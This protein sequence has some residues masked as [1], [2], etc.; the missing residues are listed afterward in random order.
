MARV[1]TKID[2][3]YLKG[4]LT[5]DK[6]LT[7]EYTSDSYIYKVSYNGVK[8]LL[9]GFRIDSVFR[10]DA[11]IKNIYQEYFSLKAACKSNSHIVKPLFLDYNVNV[12]LRNGLQ[13]YIE[14][15][16]ENPGMSL[17]EYY[18]QES[19]SL[20]TTYNLMKQSINT[21]LLLQ[22]I[23]IPYFNINPLNM[24]LLDFNENMVHDE[25]ILKIIDMGKLHNRVEERI[26]NNVI[27]FNNVLITEEYSPPEVLRLYKKVASATELNMEAVMVH[28]WAM[29]FNSLILK[30]NYSEP[31]SEDIKCKL[32]AEKDYR[33]YIP[34]ADNNSNLIVS[35][36]TIE[37]KCFIKRIISNALEYTP[38]KRPKIRDIVN[39][40]VEFEK[41]KEINLIGLSSLVDRGAI[42]EEKKSDIK[43]CGNCDER[44]LKK[45]ELICGH[46]ICKDCLIEYALKKFM[47]ITLYKYKFKCSICNQYNTLK[48]IELDCGCIESDFKTNVKKCE[49]EHLLTSIDLGLINDYTSFEHTTIMAKDHRISGKLL[50]I[51]N[52]ALY[53]RKVEEMAWAIRYVITKFSLK[54]KIENKEIG[55]IGKALEVSKEIIILDL[56]SNEIKKEGAKIIS[57]ALEINTTLK[58]LH[59][60]QNEI[61]NEGAKAIGEMLRVNKTL[62]ELDLTN[63]NIG[64]EG[65][66]AIVKGLKV[67]KMLTKLNLEKNFIGNLIADILKTNKILTELKLQVNG[68]GHTKS[69]G[70]G[71]MVN[72]II[73]ILDLENNNIGQES[74]ESISKA[75]KT[76]SSLKS[77]NL[78]F[79]IIKNEGA[80]HIGEALRTNKN[81]KELYLWSNKIEDAI[82]IGNGLKF[83]ENLT[84]LE[85]GGNM[86]NK[87]SIKVISEALV[88]KSKLRRLGL[89]YNHIEDAEPICEAL[90]SNKIL[91]ELN[92]CGNGIKDAKVIGIMLKVNKAL[93]HLDLGVNQIGDEGISCINE[94][95]KLNRTLKKLNIAKNSFSKEGAELLRKANNKTRSISYKL[96]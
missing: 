42:E 78:N 15:L 69:I 33:E 89:G 37:L 47:W 72:Q 44:I 34:S 92:L 7:S 41:T 83:N 59:L 4:H 81:L 62:T 56:C 18:E 90:K 86:L 24:T 51:Y 32:K 36:N 76:Y 68:I 27:E 13:L 77:L 45:V 38:N 57:K 22:N 60:K 61:G 16:F 88:N 23:G 21:L 85:L 2:I 73:T 5:I 55:L 17:A 54:S 46:V 63:N 94:A 93:R 35:E 20:R 49:R 70:E 19:V 39:E 25:N 96:Y 50:D 91:A 6:D 14:I 58:V 52:K 80:L 95:L 29:T 65:G 82:A 28:S 11:F 1:Q 48:S 12:T 67:N 30:K 79:N 43:P 87:E 26:A 64:K 74:A 84:V 31:R 66:K 71:L 53:Q 3:K 40:I 75:L 8:Y 10:K 9:K